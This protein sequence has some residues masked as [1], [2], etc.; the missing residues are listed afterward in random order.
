MTVH[1]PSQWACDFVKKNKLLLSFISDQAKSFYSARL[2]C[3]L[4]QSCSHYDTVRL[5]CAGL[6]G[7][8]MYVL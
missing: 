7:R 4:F 6:K 1:L 3:S 5:S 2:P 8:E